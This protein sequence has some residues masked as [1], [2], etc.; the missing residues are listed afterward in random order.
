MRAGKLRHYVTINV[1]TP[2]TSG[3][4]GEQ[5]AGYVTGDSV[6][7]GLEPLTMRETLNAQQVQGVSTHRI[8][9]RYTG[10][11]NRQDQVLFNGR[12]FEVDSV[13]NTEERNI[14]LVLLAHE[15]T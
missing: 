13:L 14:E 10:D 5:T 11:I 7:A 6:W 8:W 1:Y 12:A 15:I 2:A 4:S 3:V 9:M